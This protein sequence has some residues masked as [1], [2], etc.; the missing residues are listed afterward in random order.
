MRVSSTRNS[1]WVSRH[2]DCR[3]ARSSAARRATRR[4]GP[5]GR[6]PRHDQVAD[7]AGRRRSAPGRRPARAPRAPR[8]ARAGSREAQARARPPGLRSIRQDRK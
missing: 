2:R 7:R 4:S 1:R 3:R 5:R 8:P 6:S